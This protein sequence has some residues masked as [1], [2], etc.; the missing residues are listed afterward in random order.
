MPAATCHPL[1]KALATNSTASSFASK[2][3]T[4]TKPSGAGVFDLY[5]IN[6]GLAL[7]T[8]VPQY[9]FLQPYGGNSNDETFD[10]RLYGWNTLQDKGVADHGLWVP[11]L[12]VE[13]NVTLGN[14]AATDLGANML[15]SDTLVIVKGD[16]V[17]VSPA[18]NTPAFIKLNMLG[19]QL[20]EFDFDLTGTGDAAN[21]LWKALDHQ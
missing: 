1:R 6:L 10:I 13:A 9:I 15:I 16:T 18:N 17:T 19:A 8:Q 12:L 20:I 5:D 4:L 3:P 2:A 21:C 7:N 14:I 11:V